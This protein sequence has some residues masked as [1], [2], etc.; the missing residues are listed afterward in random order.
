MQVRAISFVL[1]FTGSLLVFRER[2][3]FSDSAD[4]AF[5]GTIEETLCP[6]GFIILFCT[7]RM[8]AY[9]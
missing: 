5:F 4:V 3:N 7:W 9:C 1:A 2:E 6:D 8:M